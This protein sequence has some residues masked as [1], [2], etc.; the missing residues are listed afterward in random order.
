[1]EDFNEMNKH[2]NFKRG[3]PEE[4]FKLLDKGGKGRIDRNGL[5]YF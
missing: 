4:I 3:S 2:L 1:L 5:L